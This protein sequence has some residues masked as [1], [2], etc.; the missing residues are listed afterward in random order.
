MGDNADNPSGHNDLRVG[1]QLTAVG[2]FL[3]KEGTVFTFDPAVG[4]PED[5]QPGGG[6]ATPSFTSTIACDIAFFDLMLEND[7]DFAP[8]PDGSASRSASRIAVGTEREV[9]GYLSDLAGLEGDALTDALAAYDEA[10]RTAFAPSPASEEEAERLAA[11]D[12]T[13]RASDGSSGVTVNGNLDLD[14]GNLD[15]GGNTFTLGDG[16]TV[17]GRESGNGITGGISRVVMTK[18]PVTLAYPVG[19]NALLDLAL[20]VRHW[21]AHRTTYTVEEIPE[22]APALFKPPAITAVSD[23]R[24]FTVEKEGAGFFDGAPLRW[25]EIAVPYG[26]DD[27]LGDPAAFRVVRSSF[28]DLFYVDLGGTLAEGS[29]AQSG[30]V[31]SRRFYWF[32]GS[33]FALATTADPA[34]PPVAARGETLPTA[35]ALDP[36]YPNPAN[37]ATTIAYA[38][39]EPAAVTLRVYDLLGREVATLVEAEQAAGFYES[40]LR[41][42][43]LASGVYLYRLDAGPFSATERLTVVK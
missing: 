35:F 26:P 3:E 28:F 19:G 38:L 11:S 21:T 29:D 12:V 33:L 14:G 7:T 32:G 22:A 40:V 13:A 25:A 31:E 15:T 17:S 27:A 6:F 18:E 23:V 30:A 1:R 2:T 24:H 9:P 43:P 5:D 16:A 36:S 34:T 42:A 39:P 37:R 20:T 4:F 10:E 41:T 8:C